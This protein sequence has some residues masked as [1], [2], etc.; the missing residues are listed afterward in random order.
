MS[1]IRVLV[2]DDSVV[3][4]RM[5]SDILD[6]DPAIEV[7]GVAANG[8]IAIAK[9][10]RTHPDVIL[11]DVEMP[12]MDGLETLTVIRQQHPNLPVIMF[13]SLTDRGSI[14]TIEALSLG[15]SDY[16]TKPNNMKSQEDAQQHIQTKLI[17]KIKELCEPTL[18][19]TLSTPH[20]PIASD[21]DTWNGRIIP[22][23]IELL[24]I[25]V[26]T[27]GPQALETVLSQFPADFPIPI[28]IVQHMPPVFTQR[29]AQRLTRKSQ[30]RVEEGFTGA[31][32]E[33]GVVWI[34]PGDYHMVLEQY[35]GRVRVNLNQDSP[36][37]SCRPAVDVMFRS[38][39]KTYGAGTLAVILT[40][41]GQDG[42]L[43]CQAVRDSG[44]QV[45]VQDEATSVV[46]G[47]PGSVANAGLAQ[48]ILPLNAIAS[49]ILHQVLLS[50]KPLRV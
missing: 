26:S 30:L 10:D 25:G 3:V 44:G 49:E 36:E 31:I 33:P 4:R 35:G 20:C 38:A 11:L 12:E 19:T 48:Q 45:L 40:G 34:A 1:K 18:S 39:A 29:L 22:T 47:M 9:L 21:S 8:R 14:A 46:W 23:R 28:A 42:L 32:L 5:V 24:A 27:G 2:V 6:S 17:P 37:H 15:A 41:M 50:S 13:S 7:V 16:C 43:G